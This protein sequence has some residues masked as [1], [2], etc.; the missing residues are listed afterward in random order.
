MWMRGSG[1]HTAVFALGT[2]WKGF[3]QILKRRAGKSHANVETKK[4]IGQ[5]EGFALHQEKIGSDGRLTTV[6]VCTVVNE[7]APRVLEVGIVH[8][9]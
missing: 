9:V 1:W 3:R 5:Q 2:G 4:T 8:D 6:E 7:P